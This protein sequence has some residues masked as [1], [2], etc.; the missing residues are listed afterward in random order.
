[1]GLGDEAEE[2]GF[3]ST[4]LDLSGSSLFQSN[5]ILNE[6]FLNETNDERRLELCCEV[7]VVQ[8]YCQTT[9]LV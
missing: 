3:V 8:R 6:A 7:G 9:W 2:V 5:D 4:K 1:L